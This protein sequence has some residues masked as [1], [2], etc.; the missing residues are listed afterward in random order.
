MKKVDLTK[1]KLRIR[2]AITNMLLAVLP[3]L[4]FSVITYGVFIN[5][6]NKLITSTLTTTFNQMTDRMNEYFN[7]VNTIIKAFAFDSTVQEI[8]STNGAVNNQEDVEKLQAQLKNVVLLNST[9]NSGYVVTNTGNIIGTGDEI[10]QN[11]IQ[12]LLVKAEANTK[13]GAFLALNDQSNKNLIAAVKLIRNVENLDK[14]GYVIMLIDKNKLLQ[15][16]DTQIYGANIQFLVVDSAGNPV[17]VPETGTKIP[18]FTIHESMPEDATTYTSSVEVDDVSYKYVIH[19]GDQTDWEFIAVVPERELYSKSWKI[20]YNILFYI[21]VIVFIII[22]LTTIANFRITKPITTLAEAIDRVASGDF[23]HKI[24][25]SE[26]NEI[27]AIADNFNHMVNEVQALTKKI[28]LTQQQLYES[29]LE[30]KQFELSLLHSQINSHFL[31]NTLSCIR[32]MSRSGAEKEVSAMISCLVSM[33]RYASNFQD[34]SVL[35]DEFTNIKNYVYIQRMRIGEQLQLIFDA[36]DD[37]LNCEIPKMTLQPVV[38]NSILHGFNNQKDRW[39]IRIAA[40]SLG[41]TLQICVMDNGTGIPKERLKA[42]NKSLTTK[43]S[44]YDTTNEKTSIGLVNIQNRI[45][46]LYG[47]EYG[48]IVRSWEEFGTAVVIQIPNK[49]SDDYVFRT[50]D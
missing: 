22:T 14:L 48:I 39:M 16:F 21:L 33:L 32:G 20:G 37:I 47:E 8:L 49:R 15:I 26:K 4:L 7:N 36:K 46:S 42:L 35:Q 2:M 17:I 34:K 10:T 30:R 38:E 18:V 3:L 9:I 19:K 25:F 12:E 31:Y 43:K 45:H 50:F 23:K 11:T 1:Y 41:K 40:K 44:I 6:S 28:F 13:N 24:S 27:T 29:E 5:D